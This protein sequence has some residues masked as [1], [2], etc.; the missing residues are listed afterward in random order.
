MS[1]PIFEVPEYQ[2]LRFLRFGNEVNLVDLFKEHW[3]ASVPELVIGDTAQELAVAQAFATMEGRL[4]MALR[5]VPAE[6]NL[7]SMELLVLVPHEGRRAYGKA[8]FTVTVNPA[9]GERPIPAGTIVRYRNT[10]LGQTI[11]FQTTEDLEILGGASY[12]EVGI[13]A[14]EIGEEANGVLKGTGLALESPLIYVEAV[15]VTEETRAGE[16]PESQESFETR[17]AALRARIATTLV[18][19]SG[20]L[21]DVMSRPEVGRARVLDMYDPATGLQDQAGF[22][23]VVATDSTGEPLREADRLAL[24]KD[25]QA[26]ALASL[27]ISVVNPDYTEVTLNVEIEAN[28][29]GDDPEAVRAQVEAALRSWLSPANWDWDSSLDDYDVAIVA[30]RVQGVTDILSIT[31]KTISLPGVAPLTRVGALNVTV[32]NGGA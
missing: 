9:E 8:G 25:L 26:Q 31:P 18:T 20:F 7:Q 27:S 2:A 21:G 16:G 28:R 12:G 32:N 23:T 3:R 29:P 17:S 30:G 6:V 15:H 24:E 4:V 13:E 14:L 19:P 22:V 5:M 1:E 10:T 11:D